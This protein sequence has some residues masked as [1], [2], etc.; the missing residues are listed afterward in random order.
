MLKSPTYSSQ[1]ISRL[2][3]YAHNLSGE[4][5]RAVAAWSGKEIASFPTACANDIPPLVVKARAAQKEWISM[6]A[7]RRALVFRRFATLAWRHRDK[8]IVLSQILSGASRIDALD[9]TI[10]VGNAASAVANLSKRVMGK[11]RRPS[12]LPIASSVHAENIPVGVVAFFTLGDF[13]ISYASMDLLQPFAA[14]NAVIQYAPSQ[15]VLGSYAMRELAIAAGMPKDLWQILPGNTIDTGVECLD[16]VDHVA[17]IGN[18]ADGENIAKRASELFIG[19][20]LFLSHKNVAVVAHDADIDN[21]VRCLARSVFIHGGASSNNIERIWVHR[22]IYRDFLKAFRRHIYNHVRIGK[23]FD[24]TA[25]LGST[26]SQFRFDRCRAHVQD[27]LDLGAKVVTGAKARPDLGPWF[28]EPT[29]LTSVSRDALMWSEETYGPVT[30]V[31]PYDS[32]DEPCQDL[33]S[34][35]YAH[36]LTMYTHSQDVIDALS[37]SSSAGLIA[38]NDSFI[39]LWA[40]KHSSISSNRDTGNGIRFGEEGLLQYTYPR[41]VN[42][43]RFGNLEPCDSLPPKRYETLATLLLNFTFIRRL[44]G[45]M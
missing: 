16:L 38:I 26:Y 1:F 14:G 23:S 35:Q 28:Y 9:E 19:S 44:F 3:H 10:E 12:I 41:S 13:P 32:L 17:Y 7:S 34:S 40:N 8:L 43:Q 22:S 2:A 4:Q 15:A 18:T 20:S 31:E 37:S 24:H 29:V 30:N 21:A 27:A 36:L 45:L 42:Y 33:T 6:S 5:G 39:Y 11:Q 25:T